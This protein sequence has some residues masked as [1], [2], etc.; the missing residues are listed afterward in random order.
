MLNHIYMAVHTHEH[1]TRVNRGFDRTRTLV[2]GCQG[3]RHADQRQLR[4][5]AQCCLSEMITCK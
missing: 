3:G 5:Y 1:K 2:G 4:Q